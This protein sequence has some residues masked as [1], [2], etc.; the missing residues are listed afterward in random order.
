MGWI[1]ETDTNRCPE[2][3]EILLY[4]HTVTSAAVYDTKRAGNDKMFDSSYT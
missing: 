2:P 3:I 4:E 1:P